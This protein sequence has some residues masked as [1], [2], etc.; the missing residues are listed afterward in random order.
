MDNADFEG[1]PGIF[2]DS[3]TFSNDM[4]LVI[5]LMLLSVFAWIYRLNIPLFGKMISNISSSEKRQSIFET[6]EKDSFLF[7]TF[8]IFQTLLLLGIFTFSVAIKYHYFM[9]PDISTTILSVVV[10]LSIFFLFYYFKRILYALFGTI[11]IEKATNKMMLT[12]YQAL[13][14][15][16][17]IT[18]YLP[19]L[20]ILL[21]DTSLFYPITFLIISFLIFKAIL[22]FRFFNIF[23]NKNTGFFFFCLYLCA[24]EMV[25]LVFLYQGMIYIFKV[26]LVI[27]Y[28]GMV[29]TQALIETSSIIWQ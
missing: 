7:N 2:T 10:L 27:L 22:S 20:W 8:M 25:P 16:W 17:G 5:V 4:M 1:Y 28:E 15:T 6:T 13:F 23:W 14:C 18:L 11:F 24:Q 29:Y 3:I 19:V 12:N 21:F 26:P 9:N